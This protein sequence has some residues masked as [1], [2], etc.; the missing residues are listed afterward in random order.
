MKTKIQGS[1]MNRLIILFTLIST[2]LCS[3]KPMFEEQLSPRIANYTIDVI[4][5]TDEKKLYGK[6]LL[7]W[8]NDSKDE[9]NELQFHLYLNAFKNETSTFMKESK[10]WHRRSQADKKEGWGWINVTKMQTI[11]GL[12]LTN[13]IEFIQPDDL[14]KSDQTVIRVPLDKPVKPYEEIN[15]KIEFE[16]KLPKVFARTG[17]HQNFFMIGQWF[18]KIGVYEEAGERYA[19]K[20]QW[21]CHQFHLNGEFYADFGNYNVSI[22]LPQNFIVGA[23]GVLLNQKKNEDGTKTL[24]YYCEDVHDFAWTADPNFVIIEDQWKHVNIK[25][26]VQSQREGTAHRYIQAAK[27]TFEYFEEWFGEYPYPILTIVDPRY[28]ARGAGGMEYPT[29]ITTRGFW[30]YPEGLKYPE[31]VTIHE[32]GHNYWYGLIANNEFEEA[33]LDEGITTYAEIMVSEKYYNK[34][35][36]SYVDLF[37]FRISN[38]D[39]AWGYYVIGMKENDKIFNY[40]WKYET[41]GYGTNAYDKPAMMLLTLH[42]YLGEKRMKKVMRTFFDRYKFKHPTTKDFT[43]TVN[44]ISGENLDWFFDQIIYNCVILDYKLYRITNDL[45]PLKDRGF[46]D[47]DTGMVFI[48]NNELDKAKAEIYK[49]SSINKLYNSKV[50]VTREGDMTFPVEVLIKFSNNEEILEQW[51]G[52]ANYKV[53]KYEKSARVISAQIDPDRKIWLDVNPLNNGLIIKSENTTVYKY[54]TRWLYWMQNIMQLIL[55]FI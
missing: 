4:L 19:T 16:A 51:D 14:N 26:L 45:I 54:S 49:D 21:N 25:Y 34:K 15:L 22:T 31:M 10:G 29:F 18:P 28:G 8:K 23:T 46:F 1:C 11:E 12:E 50:I 52:K 30:G 17:Y 39:M 27:N 48:G 13:Q 3:Q 38:T 24:N 40:S 53:F 32:L 5:D 47:S 42:N 43:N 36:G 20:G 2:V 6:E 7:I 55:T 35:G 9:I 33:W 37:G 44:E 41:N